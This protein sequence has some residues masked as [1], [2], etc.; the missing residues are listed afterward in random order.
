MYFHYNEKKAQLTSPKLVNFINTEYQ[1]RG[2]THTFAFGVNYPFKN[3]E[4]V[5]ASLAIA[6]Q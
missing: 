5:S 4:Y 3:A 6:K 2:K 1:N